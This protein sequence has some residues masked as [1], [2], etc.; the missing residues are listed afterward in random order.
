VGDEGYKTIRP[1]KE[2]SKI[3]HCAISTFLESKTPFKK[4]NEVQKLFLE[5]LVL[6]MTKRLFPLNTGENVWM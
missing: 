6:L 4:Q 3:A 1:T 5:D 2:H